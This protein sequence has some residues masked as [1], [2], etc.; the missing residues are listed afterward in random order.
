MKEMVEQ[1][2]DELPED[3]EAHFTMPFSVCDTED[4]ERSLVAMLARRCSSCD[5][6]AVETLGGDFFECQNG[7]RWSR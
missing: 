3:G 1:P 5:L 6:R 2:P 7:H 4:A